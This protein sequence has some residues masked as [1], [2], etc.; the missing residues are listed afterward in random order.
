MLTIVRYVDYP[1]PDPALLPADPE[2]IL[3]FDIETTGFSPASSSLYLIGTMVQEQGRMKLTQWFATRMSEEEEILAA[4]GEYLTHY[5]CLI[6]FN[7]DQFDIPYL[8]KCAGA[9]RM[10]LP[11]SS[12]D[13]FDLL[14]KARE[15]KE[16]LHLS[17][18]RQKSIEQF[19]GIQRDDL[20]DGGQLIPVYQQYLR[21]QTEELLHLLLLHNAEDVTGMLQLLPILAYEKTAASLASTILEHW[22]KSETILS[23]TL[24]SSIFV[25]VPV[26]LQKDGFFLQM[27]QNLIVIGIPLFHGELKYYYPDYKDY[28][29]LPQEDMAIHQKVACFVDKEHRKKATRTTAYTR[30]SGVFL[31]LPS[32]S[33]KEPPV[34]QEKELLCLKT[35]LK[36]KDRFVTLEEREDYLLLI[37]QY[38][39][40]SLLKR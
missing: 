33:I 11:F 20:Y 32:S 13:S 4:F 23:I 22:E 28:Y 12:C 27:E 37:G 30:K 34:F 35:D 40:A 36:A 21:S 17:S 38:V 24:T 1:L 7:G 16:L 8:E 25:P 2:Q 14:K 15:Q 18:Y 39:A 3:F 6:H 29:Y 10:T 9:Y 19:L 26:T 31:K 5:S